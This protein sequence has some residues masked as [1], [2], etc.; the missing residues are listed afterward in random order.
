MSKG[1]LAVGSDFIVSITGFTPNRELGGVKGSISPFC[2]LITPG[3]ISFWTDTCIVDNS[4]VVIR[5]R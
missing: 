2:S 4:P 3:A 1:N 5:E